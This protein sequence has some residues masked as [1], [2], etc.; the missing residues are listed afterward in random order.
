MFSRGMD[1]A[2]Y[3]SVEDR[4]MREMVGRER[5]E[6]VAQVDAIGKMI[7]RVF[8]VDADKVFGPVV[9]EYA[10]EVYQE[11]YDADLLRRKIAMRRAAHQRVLAK[12]RMDEQLIQRLDRMGDFYDQQFGPLGAPLTPAQKPKQNK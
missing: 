2:P 8:G 5:A 12:R 6:K 4:V 9:A 3:G 7:A 11:S 10:A 1:L